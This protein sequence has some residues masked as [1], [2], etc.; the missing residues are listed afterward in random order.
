MSE[1]TELTEFD[2]V[3]RPSVAI[4]YNT[5]HYAWL[6]RSNLIRSLQKSGYS[7]VVLAPRDAYTSRLIDLGAS[8]IDIPM[9]MNTN[10]ISDLLLL[11]RFYRR[12]QEQ[13][14]QVYLGFT[15][16]PNVYGSLAAHALHFRS[17]IILPGWAPCSSKKP[18]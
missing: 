5:S 17:S 4:G 16:K 7:V 9:T 10:P 11:W 13:K 1:L 6:L 14:P 2:S 12:L 18:G 8:H 15:I 3:N